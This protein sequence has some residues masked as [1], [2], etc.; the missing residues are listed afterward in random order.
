MT[1]ASVK[2]RMK[3]PKAKLNKTQVRRVRQG[4]ESLAKLA[5][6]FGI[7]VPALIQVRKRTTYKWVK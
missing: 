6:E 5:R 2:G 4:K 7:T 1:D 3:S